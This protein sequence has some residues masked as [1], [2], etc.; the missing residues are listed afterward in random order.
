MKILNFS[1]QMETSCQDQW[2][3]YCIKLCH[4][5][6]FCFLLDQDFLI[7]DFLAMFKFEFRHLL[8]SIVFSCALAAVR[9]WWIRDSYFSLGWNHKEFGLSIRFKHKCLNKNRISQKDSCQ[10]NFVSFKLQKFLKEPYHFTQDFLWL[11]FHDNCWKK[12]KDIQ[13]FT[14]WS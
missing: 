8:W 12:N 13:R 2:C 14:S 3:L 7:Y 4:T 9:L 11:H 5:F 10:L 6:Q 1:R